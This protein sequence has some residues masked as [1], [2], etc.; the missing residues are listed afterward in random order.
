MSRPDNDYNTTTYFASMNDGFEDYNHIV[1]TTM[2]GLHGTID[3]E[4]GGY[5]LLHGER[6]NFHHATIRIMLTP[7]F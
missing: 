6:Q 5:D 4:Q 2:G 7:N 1:S 3:R